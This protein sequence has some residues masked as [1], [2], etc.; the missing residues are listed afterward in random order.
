MPNNQPIINPGALL[1]RLDTRDYKWNEVASILPPF[2]WA[3]GYSVL[4]D[5]RNAIGNPLF[6][7]KTKDQGG[8]YSCGGQS[9]AYYGAVL[10]SIFSKSYEERSAKFIYAQ[11]YVPGG[12]SNGRDNCAIVAKH[13]WGLESLTPSYQNTQPPGEYFMEQGQ[14]ITDTARSYASLSR[15]VSYAGVD[16]DIDHLAQSCK[17]NHGT[18]IGISGS[19]N[20]TWFSNKPKPPQDGEQFWYHWLY[21][22]G[23]G[24]FEGEK[25]LHVL[26]S[27]GNIAGTFGWQWITESYLNQKIASDPVH[28]NSTIFGAWTLIYNTAQFPQPDY[29]HHF[30]IEMT[31]GD[32]SDE[33]RALQTAL[34]LTGDFPESVPV[35]GFY[36]AITAQSVYKF[37]TRSG[38]DPTSRNHA[39]PRTCGAL[40]ALFDK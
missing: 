3:K 4:D 12:G 24:M 2:D 14:D 5:I 36:G 9:W 29:H 31:Y 17:N 33:V 27:W 10:E 18:I 38:I 11:T 8:S 35:S 34:Q 7:L 23:A 21:V 13:G 37:Q 39:G 16:L 32:T 1:D 26:N 40:N 19:N 30:G 15:A 22:G 20:G 28:N 6:T 25:A